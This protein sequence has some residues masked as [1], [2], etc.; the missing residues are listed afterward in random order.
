MPHDGSLLQG[1][2]VFL[3]AAVLA[4]PL[5]KRLQLGAVLGY[6]L[7][8]V[9]I[10][11]SVLGLIGDPESVS[12]LSEMGVVLLLFIIGLELSP[13]RL[14]VMRQAVFGVGLAQVLLTA[15]VIGTVAL[16]G[17]H[18]PLPV[19]MVLG[20][21]LALSST[22]FGLQLLAERKELTSPHGRMAFA[23]LLFQDIAANP[24]IALVPMLGDASPH[25]LPG[26][27][28][29]GLL[30]VFGSIAL[31]VLGGRYLLRP[32]FRI[33]S[34]SGSHEVSTATALLV[35]I[36]TAWLMELAGISMALGAF[37]AGMLLADSE[38]RHELESHIEPFKGLLLGLFFMSVGMVANLQL[39]WQEPLL[40][41]G[42]TLLLIGLKL[43]V[44]LLVG[45]LAGGLSRSSAMQLAVL[46]A[47]GGEFA[48][49]VFRMARSEQ[50]LDAHIHDLLVIAITLSMAVTPLL[51]MLVAHLFKSAPS[52][53]SEVPPELKTVDSHTPRV[54]LAG[55]GR[56]GQVIARVLRAQHVPFVAL[57]NSVDAVEM[58]RSLGQMPIFYGNPLRPEIL[59]AAQV[60]K[61][62]WFIVA[63]DDPE[64]NLKTTELV[65]KLYPH[66]KVIARARNRQ[67]VHK[68]WDLNA[69][70]VR[71]TFHSSLEMSHQVLRGL[72]LSEEQAAARLRRFKRHDEEVLEAQHRVYDNQA[73]VQQTARQ[74]RDELE[75]LFNSDQIDERR[76]A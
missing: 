67:H 22:A 17:F 36:G 43:P 38:Y 50:L 52:A 19:A 33:V 54:V 42:L 45:R 8:G 69:L 48:F 70:A 15:L 53:P 58:S 11:P 32:V 35:V 61:A 27:E 46:L 26:N 47:A 3:C 7:A 41:L 57:D 66:V 24:L 76:D 4:V 25:P 73:E 44:L 51:V 1:A 21:G 30:E 14:W 62:E 40:V 64:T 12:H 31:V 68:L 71:E 2:V 5:A 18:Q 16:F 28:L 63:T 34:R 13:K 74:A 59:R 55:M 9:L 37:L 10:G 6:L 23:I 39:L 49:V 72:G 20:L 60:D 29:Q 75:N 56:M 65:R